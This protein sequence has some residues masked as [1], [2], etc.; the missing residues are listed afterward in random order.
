MLKI[1]LIPEYSER[2]VNFLPSPFIFLSKVL[3]FQEKNLKNKIK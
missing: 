3:S 2:F 1:D